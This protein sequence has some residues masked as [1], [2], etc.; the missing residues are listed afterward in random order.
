MGLGWQERCSITKMWPGEWA[1]LHATLKQGQININ[2]AS[3]SIDGHAAGRRAWL[4]PG[5][6]PTGGSRCLASVPGDYPLNPVI[7]RDFGLWQYEELGF[8][9]APLM[10]LLTLLKRSS[11]KHARNLCAVLRISV[12]AAGISVV[13]ESVKPD[14]SQGNPIPGSCTWFAALLHQ[15]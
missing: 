12:S 13:S 8:V 10:L 2:P 9:A 11:I 14:C 3:R 1:R 7:I 6:R 15:L 5:W 4:N